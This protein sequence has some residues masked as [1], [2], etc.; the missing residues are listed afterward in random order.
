[1]HACSVDFSPQTRPGA[2]EAADPGGRS[3]QVTCTSERASERVPASCRSPRQ[4]I[5]PSI[6]SERALPG[7]GGRSPTVPVRS[8]YHGVHHRAA[9]PGARGDRA[10]RAGAGGYPQQAYDGRELG[11][12]FLFFTLPLALNLFLISVNVA[13]GGAEEPAK[14]FGCAESTG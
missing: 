12:V 2:R 9:A 1:M 6:K 3:A 10:V 4:P 11:V 5:H 13:E 14:G 8:P 7:A